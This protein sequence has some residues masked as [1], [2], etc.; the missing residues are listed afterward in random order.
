MNDS[1]L[2]PEETAILIDYA[3][4]KYHEERWPLSDHLREVR[5]ALM[6]LRPKPITPPAAPPRPYI[7]ASL[8]KTRR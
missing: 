7:P 8:G 6:K 4:Q 2:S 1:G 3:R 5:A